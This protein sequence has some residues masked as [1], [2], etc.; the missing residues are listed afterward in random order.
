[1][2]YHTKKE[3]SKRW[4]EQEAGLVSMYKQCEG[5]D[6]IILFCEGEPEDSAR[7]G[8]KRKH[9]TGPIVEVSDHEE[10]VKQLSLITMGK[11]GICVSINYGQEGMFVR[12]GR[13]SKNLLISLCWL[14]V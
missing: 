4:I 13:V 8:Q 6:I 5:C 2:G 3:N 9:A 10:Q 12:T 7:N 11:N 14:E 1:L